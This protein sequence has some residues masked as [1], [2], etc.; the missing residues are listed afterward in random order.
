MHSD[1]IGFHKYNDYLISITLLSCLLLPFQEDFFFSRI[2]CSGTAV[3]LGSDTFSDAALKWKSL[4]TNFIETEALYY[5][6]YVF[7]IKYYS[8]CFSMGCI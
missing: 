5:K 8:S 6:R 4:S 7:S 2:V 3:S 1:I